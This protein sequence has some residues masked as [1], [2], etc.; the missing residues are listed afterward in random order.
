MPPSF[1]SVQHSFIR[2]DLEFQTQ[3]GCCWMTMAKAYAAARRRL[4]VQ[5]VSAFNE[6]YTRLRG[7]P[8]D[9]RHSNPYYKE[10][11]AK[12]R[13]PDGVDADPFRSSERVDV[14]TRNE[15]RAK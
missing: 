11:S 13:S 5:R 1:S 14:S 6:R 10:W 4:L 2:V 3:S 15:N 7:G 12:V 8:A 9:P